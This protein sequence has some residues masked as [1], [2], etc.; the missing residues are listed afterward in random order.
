MSEAFQDPEYIQAIQK[1]REEEMYRKGRRDVI[2]VAQNILNDAIA[3]LTRY[4]EPSRAVE[5]GSVDYQHPRA[6][7]RTTEG[8]DDKATSR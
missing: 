7:H 5:V 3:S 4:E 6:G 1:K 8:R 2:A